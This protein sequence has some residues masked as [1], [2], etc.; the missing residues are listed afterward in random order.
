MLDQR[1]PD[2]R[3]GSWRC[4][5]SME[6]LKVAF[7]SLKGHGAQVCRDTSLVF[8]SRRDTKGSQQRAS[9]CQFSPPSS[10]GGQTGC[11]R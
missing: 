9:T 7:Q 1:R 2:L 10:V 11:H 5:Y 3:A 4:S 6:G 8:P